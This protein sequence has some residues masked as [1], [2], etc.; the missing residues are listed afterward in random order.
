MAS[1]AGLVGN[2]PDRRAGVLGA[3]CPPRPEEVVP[4][5]EPVGGASRSGMP[6]GPPS[7][8]KW[9][10]VADDEARIRELWR[11]ALG[12]AGYRTVEASTGRDAVEIMRAVVPD[13]IILDV[14]MP[15]LTGAEALTLIGSAPVLRTI[16]VLVVSGYP[17]YALPAGLDLNIV[18]RLAKPVSLEE[19]VRRVRA[20]L[21]PES[22]LESRLAQA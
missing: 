21:E 9:I 22:G 19:L 18:G 7:R 6:S 20:V 11:E 16:P 2:S 1:R 17:D 3:D 8:R 5:T 13:L 15:E 4:L 10:L 12:Q 14:R